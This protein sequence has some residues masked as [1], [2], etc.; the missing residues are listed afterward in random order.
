MDWNLIRSFLIVAETGTLVQ[1][2]HKLKL[3]QPTLGRHINE[4]EEQMGLALFVRSRSGMTLTDAGLTLVEDAR[5][6]SADAENFLLKAAGRETVLS[7]TVRITASEV[8]ATYLLPQILADLRDQE[9]E[10]EIELVPT[11]AVENLLSRDADIAVRM[12]QP[13]QGDVIARKVNDLEMGSYATKHYIEK[14]GLPK[15][16]GELLKHRLVGYDRS[17][18]ILKQMKIFGYDVHRRNFAFRTDNQVAN[19]ELVKSG[20]GIGFGGIYLASLTENLV[21]V[22][23]DLA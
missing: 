1:S 11:N 8:V 21:R 6:M 2:A 5:R 20:A 17:D 15:S 23:P 19:W 10:V 18:L 16:P 13:G 14:F 12:V 4:L 7:G 3:S 22:L 9:P